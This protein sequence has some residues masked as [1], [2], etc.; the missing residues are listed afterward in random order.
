MYSELFMKLL[1]LWH[2]YSWTDTEKANYKK[3]VNEFEILW[4]KINI[5]KTS[6]PVLPDCWRYLKF[7][8]TSPASVHA[9]K[10]RLTCKSGQVYQPRLL[11][12]KIQDLIL[13]TQPGHLETN[14][15]FSYLKWRQTPPQTGSS[16]LKISL[17]NH[18]VT[19][20]VLFWLEREIRMVNLRS[21]FM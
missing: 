1:S 19:I 2:W 17:M 9:L 11:C 6:I 10:F 4:F 12:S 21:S 3:W 8:R 13:L 16:H 14:L 18:P 5:L 15:D 7:F 20:S